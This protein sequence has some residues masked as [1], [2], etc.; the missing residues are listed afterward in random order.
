M[1]KY[2]LK[3]KVKE[4]VCF[5]HCNLN[6]NN[7]WFYFSQSLIDAHEDGPFH[8]RLNC[9]ELR[10]KTGNKVF[11]FSLQWLWNYGSFFLP[12]NK[13]VK[14]V[15]ATFSQFDF[16][17]LVYISIRM[18]YKLTILRKSPNCEIY[19]C[20][21]EKKSEL[22]DKVTISFFIFLFCKISFH[23]KHCLVVMWIL[24]FG[25][26]NERFELMMQMHE[27]SLC[28]YNFGK[29]HFIVHYCNMVIFH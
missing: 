6:S 7:L 24:R 13:N 8:I 12:Q 11:L 23:V 9:T 14:K 29:E 21:Y 5:R 26:Y 17:F 25:E 3:A 10:C 16:F 22:C 2:W 20:N 4:L 27:V 28:Y 19:I 18:R 15:I 1:D